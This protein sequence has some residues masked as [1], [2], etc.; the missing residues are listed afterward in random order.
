LQL[1]GAYLDKTNKLKKRKTEGGA[2]S[3]IKWTE[4]GVAFVT[5]RGRGMRVG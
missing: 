1:S 4:K 5:D 3:L 2:L